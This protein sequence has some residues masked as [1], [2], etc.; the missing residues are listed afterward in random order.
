M[1][2]RE[3]EPIDEQDREDA[4]QRADH[5]RSDAEYLSR[6]NAIVESAADP[7]KN[8]KIV[9]LLKTSPFIDSLVDT[10]V[11]DDDPDEWTSPEPEP[12][13]DARPEREDRHGIRD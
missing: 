3:P 8:D 10:D 11:F 4:A 6:L 12:A 7:E 2:R 1:R 5:A 9:A 13:P